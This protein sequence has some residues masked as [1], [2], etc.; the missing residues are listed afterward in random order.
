MLILRA[1]CSYLTIAPKPGMRFT[2]GTCADIGR[3]EAEI[4]RRSQTHSRRCRARRPGASGQVDVLLDLGELSGIAA[5][6]AD[7]SRGLDGDVAGGDRRRVPHPGGG[8]SR[9]SL[10]AVAA[11]GH[12]SFVQRRESGDQTGGEPA[13]C[14]RC[15]HP[16][17]RPTPSRAR[18]S[19]T[20]GSRSRWMRPS[21]SSG[22]IRAAL[23]D[24]LHGASA[25]P[26]VRSRKR[27]SRRS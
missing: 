23:D 13:A 26:V 22:D 1:S 12:G 16:N 14:G 5:Q 15:D 25:T 4:G 10:R 9:R 24:R 8:D 2:P 17:A 20:T 7:R 3:E 18:C 19:T 11:E 27:S 6:R 21:L